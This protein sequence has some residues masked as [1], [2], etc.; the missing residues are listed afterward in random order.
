MWKLFFDTLQ[1]R[2]SCGSSFSF[3]GMEGGMG[4]IRG[5]TLENLRQG[6]P[7]LPVYF[8]AYYLSSLWLR[9]GASMGAEGEKRRKKLLL[10]CCGIYTVAPVTPACL[11]S[12]RVCTGFHLL[13][14][15][16]GSAS[17][18]RNCSFC[19]HSLATWA[20]FSCPNRHIGKGW[21]AQNNRSRRKRGRREQT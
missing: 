20:A 1:R 11:R 10:V 18:P 21:G 16:G 13:G 15:M 7:F 9:L 14:P 4:C 8:L 6:D 3:L 5:R 2:L 17:D 12:H 19:F